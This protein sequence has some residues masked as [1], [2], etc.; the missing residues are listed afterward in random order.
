[1]KIH[2]SDQR[3]QFPVHLNILKETEV[4]PYDKQLL[5]EKNSS[6]AIGGFSKLSELNTD[7]FFRY[8]I[9]P[10]Y[11]LSGYPQWIDEQREIQPGDTIVQQAFLPPIPVFSQKII[12]GVRIKEVFREEKRIGFSYET[13]KGHVEK[14][15]SYFLLEENSGQISFRIQTFSK[16]GNFL[17]KM[18]GPLFSLPYQN[19]CTKKAL[20]HVKSILQH[21]NKQSL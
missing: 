9:F 8:H 18:A 10:E 19:Y 21:E 20:Q 6:I 4:M 3:T 5:P 16:P 12:F 7:A 2:F 13:L 14:G 11:I 17:S 15:I 1:M